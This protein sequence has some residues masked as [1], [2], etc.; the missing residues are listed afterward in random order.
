MA[1]EDTYIAFEIL[2]PNLHESAGELG[3]EAP[4][5]VTSV[6]PDE[7]PEDGEIEEGDSAAW[8]VKLAEESE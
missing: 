5:T 7:G 8:K 3:K 1:V 6:P 2:S 4:V